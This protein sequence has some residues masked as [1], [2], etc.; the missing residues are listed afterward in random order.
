MKKLISIVLA[1]SIGL[2]LMGCGG[3]T[4][5]SDKVADTNVGSGEPIVWTFYSAYGPEDG[6]CCEIWPKGRKR[7]GTRP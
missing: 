7:M 1:M 4:G 5:A 3:S 2:S 6:A